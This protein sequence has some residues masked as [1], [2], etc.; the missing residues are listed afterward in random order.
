[1]YRQSLSWN[2]FTSSMMYGCFKRD[3][4]AFSFNTFRCCDVA[5][6][7]AFC[8]CFNAKTSPVGCN[9]EWSEG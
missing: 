7:R 9:E 8:I 2:V 3:K 4:M 1:M 6:M 5:T